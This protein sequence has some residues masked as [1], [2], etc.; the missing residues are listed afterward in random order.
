MEGEV[1][2]TVGTGCTVPHTVVQTLALRS[3]G[4]CGAVH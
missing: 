3:L 1:Y 4:Q 2:G